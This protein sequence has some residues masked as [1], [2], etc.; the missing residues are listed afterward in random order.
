LYN[1]RALLVIQSDLTKANEALLSVIAEDKNWEEK[2]GLKLRNGRKVV[3]KAAQ[4][5]GN[6]LK[7][8]VKMNQRLYETNILLLNNE[9]EKGNK[10]EV[11]EELKTVLGLLEKANKNGNTAE[12]F[13]K[14]ARVQGEKEAS[15]YLKFVKPVIPVSKETVLT[16]VSVSPDAS[17]SVKSISVKEKK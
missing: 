7:E 12:S 14:A 5:Y 11:S 4:K 15:K 13:L 9:S 8:T 6:T 1:C 2:T 10:K 17:K 16:S 3:E